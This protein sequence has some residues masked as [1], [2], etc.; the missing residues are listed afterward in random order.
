MPSERCQFLGCY[1]HMTDVLEA[2]DQERGPKKVWLCAEHRALII[3]A[4]AHGYYL[5]V[6]PG[7]NTV[8]INTIADFWFGRRRPYAT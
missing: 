4:V 5:G 6:T 2:V 1:S 7:V 3:D 8:W